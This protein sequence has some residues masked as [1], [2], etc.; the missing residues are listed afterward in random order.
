MQ[1]L[2]QFPAQLAVVVLTPRQRESRRA[3]VRLFE[4]GKNIYDSW[5]P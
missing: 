2:W 3:K 5:Q 1:K 4:K